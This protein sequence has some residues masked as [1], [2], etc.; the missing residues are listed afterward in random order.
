MSPRPR[1]SALSGRS[2]AIIGAGYSGT[3][4]ALHLLQT[5]APND[6]IILFERR[7]TFG[8]GLAYSTDNGGH[9]LN[10]RA[11]NMSAFPDQ[12][13]NFLEW[14]R[15][16]G[17][18]ASDPTPLADRFVP[19]ALYGTYLQELLRAAVSRYGGR[20]LELVQDEIAELTR[21]ENGIALRASGGRTFEVDAAVL[22]CGSFP[23]AK[24]QGA[25][26]GN[27]WAPNALKGIDP[28]RP[29]LILGTGLTM[30]DVALSLL[31]NGHRGTIHA[32]SRRGLLPRQ[33]RSKILPDP[34]ELDELLGGGATVGRIMRAVRDRI[35][36][37]QE[38]GMDWRCVIDGLRPHTEA[39]WQALSPAEA[40]RFLRHLRPWWDAH[41]HR[42]AP[43]VADAIDAARAAGRLDVFAGRVAAMDVQARRVV[44][45]YRKKGEQATRSLDVEAV[46]DCSGLKAAHA[47]SIDPLFKGLITSGDA[48]IDRFEL[49]LD[50]DPA[51]DAVIGSNG[52]AS[53]RLYAVGPMTRAAHWEM[54]AVP[55]LRIQ[56]ARV[57]AHLATAIRNPAAD[58]VHPALGWL[59]SPVAD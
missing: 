39:L 30:V 6:R 34:V 51:T 53:A 27:P 17:H 18:D 32:M 49:G 16:R 28:D 40:S 1:P 24:S 22:A 19:R 8:R 58:A 11:M 23:P 45:T 59:R 14:L 2:F 10:V 15:N 12:P 37:A 44:V 35:D 4:T 26:R 21:S 56:C 13:A 43:P 48:R 50:V 7:P 33:H 47:A 55:D 57:A 52:V 31:G 46:I 36:E 54:I 42:M 25:Y 20:T 5:S 41:R 9:L 38:L 29:V 3:L